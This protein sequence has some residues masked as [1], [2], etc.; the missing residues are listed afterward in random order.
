MRGWGERQA[1]DVVGYICEHAAP[2]RYCND[3][4]FV[5]AN[6]DRVAFLEKNPHVRAVYR[7]FYN[8]RPPPLFIYIIYYATPYIIVCTSIYTGFRVKTFTSITYN[9][10]IIIGSIASESH[11]V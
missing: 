6:D 11:A 10:I 4:V 1:A 5:Y 8:T 9:I 3:T 7:P 2:L